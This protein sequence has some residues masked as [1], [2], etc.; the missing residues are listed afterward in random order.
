MLNV[1]ECYTDED[2]NFIKNI[3]A[4]GTGIKEI[5]ENS[6]DR[7]ASASIITLVE[8]DEKP[9][10][11]IYVTHELSDNRIGFVDMGL[12]ST[13]RGYGYGK[14]SLDIFIHKTR[15]FDIF[16]IAETKK[17]NTIA[18]R[19]LS[20]YEHVY[21]KDDI[22]FYLVNKNLEELKEEGL[23]E[24]LIDHLNSDRISSKDSIKR[25]YK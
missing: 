21:D 19:I 15:N 6:R 20:N 23:Y 22:C 24:E 3:M 18:N 8:K 1:R 5:F 16:F 4:S 10:G 25:L 7:L 17:E 12:I 11:F 2:Y 14:E 9:I 13:N